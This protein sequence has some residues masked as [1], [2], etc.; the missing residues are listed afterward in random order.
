MGTRLTRA[1]QKEVASLAHKKYRE[2]RSEMLVEGKRAILAALEADAAIR[3]VFVTEAR[4]R[5]DDI[6]QIIGRAKAPVHIV[7][8]SVM[9]RLSDVESSQGLLAV[10]GIETCEFDALAG[11]RRILV[12]D[13]VQDPGNAGTVIRTAAWFGVDGVVT[14]SRTV[15]LYNPKVV[16]AAMGA[17]WDIKHAPVEDLAE[18]L[19][20]LRSR[21]FT[22]YGADMTGTDVR[23]WKPAERSVLVLGSEAHGLSSDVSDVL[24]DHIVIP[25]A[26]SRRGT[27]SLNVGVAAGILTYEWMR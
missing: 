1:R 6:Q 23:R 8:E 2:R 9:E 5:E 27:E 4:S 13:A 17:L 20:A 15:D 14:A 12:L 26:A 10:V 7:E 24:D 16:R 11:A 18:T 21:G 25:G 3:D 22:L 19:V